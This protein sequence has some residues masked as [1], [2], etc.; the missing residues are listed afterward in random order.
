MPVTRAFHARPSWS[1]RTCWIIP[2]AALSA[3]LWL[4]RAPAVEAQGVSTAVIRGTVRTEDG[5]SVEGA[6]VRVLN[7]A[8]GF[9][10]NTQVTRGRFLVHGLE[11]GGPYTVEVRRLGFLPGRSQR[12]FLTLGEPLDLRFTLTPVAAQLDTILVRSSDGALVAGGGGTVTIIPDSLVH[13]LPTLNRDFYDFV[14]LAPHVS[15]KVGLGRNGLSAAGANLRF[16]SYLVD[17]ADERGINGS[18]SASG[19]VGKSIP[20]DAV[21]QYQV[22]VAP[23][24]VRYGDFA[25]AMINTVTQSG[26]NEFRGSAFAYWRDNRLSRNAEPYERMQYGFSLGGPIIA[27]RLHFFVA[28]ELQRLTSPAP[29]PY[30]GQ[31]SSAR[32]EVP[33][34]EADVARFAA[35]MR[36]HGLAA[37]TGG[38][39]AIRGPLQN[40]FARLD[41]SLPAWRS[42]VIASAA[43]GQSDNERFSRDTLTR[44]YLSSSRHGATVGM[45]RTSLHLHSDLARSGGGHNELIVSALRDRSE[46]LSELRQPLVRVVVPGLSGGRVTLLA[47]SPE[48][49]QGPF[50]RSRSVKVKDELLLPWGARHVLVLGAQA[51]RFQVRPGGVRGGYGVWNFASLDAFAAGT[52]ERFDIRRDLG[53][54][55][56]ALRGGQ[57]AAYVGDEWSAGERVSVTLGLRGDLLSIDTRPPYNAAVDSIFSRRTDEMPRARVHLAPRLGFTWDLP[58]RAD[59]RLRGGIGLFTGRPPLAWL[60]PPLSN[61]GVGISTLTCTFA[62][63]DPPPRFAPDY[64]NPPTTCL[65]GSGPTTG[66]GEIYLLSRNLRMAEALRSSLAYDRRLSWG[67]SSSSELLLTR[68]LSDFI[69]VNRNLEGPYSID[70]AGRVMYGP[71]GTPRLRST[72]PDVM[73][74]RNTSKNHSYQLSTRLERR[75]AQGI[76]ATASYT[77]SRVRDVQSPS[78][79]NM[80]GSVMWADARAISGRHNDHVTGISLNDVPHRVVAAVAYTAP[81]PR[82]TT[83]LSFYYVGESGTPFTYLASGQSPYGDLNAD[84]SNANDPI[85]VPRDAQDS[86]GLRFDPFVRSVPLPGGGMRSDTVTVTAAQ[87]AEAFA[88]FVGSASCL[89][90]QRGR[91]MERNSCREPWSHTTTASVRQ[92]IPVGGH[93]VEAELDVF[94]VLDLLH[95][96]WGSRRAAAPWIL[97]HVGQAATLQPLVRFNPLRP[98]WTPLKTE[99]AYQMQFA[100]R[101][102]F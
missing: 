17:G 38:R 49:A 50:R 83:A 100:L 47:G 18:I 70:P 39:V 71:I 33:V 80:R 86:S 81:W 79:V 48:Q 7:T 97:E 29:G 87:Q 24:D 96:G 19:S 88:Q 91:I 101:Y 51:E 11:V 62:S 9:E 82:W 67:F 37:G 41:A 30:I 99:S 8:S 66:R 26:T 22:L 84:G 65:T 73:E 42:R 89:R 102:R 27:N 3:S 4:V 85:Y 75:F 23:Y 52:A 31:P 6:H 44:F 92:S 28:P 94:N 14:Q 40:L 2:I 16:N 1:G 74:L 5:A 46:Q 93:S 61:N 68:Y 57:Y 77:F 69:W 72:Y 10:L 58:G 43:F 63:E 25:G 59:H 34:S 54:A 12:L 36:D 21:K 15:T 78:R 32:P 98:T 35:L 53:S 13:R 64:R 76:A 90:R 45:M 56:A 55:G 95:A 20:L 60:Q